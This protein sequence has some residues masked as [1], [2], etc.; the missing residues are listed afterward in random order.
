M[1]IQGMVSCPV[2]PLGNPDRWAVTSGVAGFDRDKAN[3]RRDPKM[4]VNWLS[5]TLVV[6]AISLIRNTS[7]LRLECSNRLPTRSAR[8]CYLFSRAHCVTFNLGI[9]VKSKG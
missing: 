8:G 3:T 5:Y 2:Q 7:I 6:L 9:Q 4:M 1:S